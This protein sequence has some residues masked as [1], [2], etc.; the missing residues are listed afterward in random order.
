MATR[1]GKQN[2]TVNGD[3]SPLPSGDSTEVDFK[4]GWVSVGSLY[5]QIHIDDDN[6]CL[7]RWDEAESMMEVLRSVL[8]DRSRT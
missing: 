5:L 8:E 2:M 6:D 1:P 3:T 7:M 4:G